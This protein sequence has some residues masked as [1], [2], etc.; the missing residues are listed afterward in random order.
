M[1]GPPAYPP[2]SAQP[3]SGQPPELPGCVRHPDRPTGLRCVRCDRPSCHECLR[4]AS[5]GYQCVDC[6]SVGR[7]QVRSPRTVAG[8]AVGGRAVVVPVLVAINLAVYLFTAVQARNPVD[9]Y[10][11]ALFD[12]WV[13][14]PVAVAD[15]EWWRLLTAG[16]LHYGPVHV[17]MNMLALWLIGRQLEPLLGSV[18][19]AAVYVLSLLGGS[20]AVF[21]FGAI[22]VAAAG[23]STGV[24][25]LFGAMLMAFLR[26]KLSLRP[27]LP[28][29]AINIVISLLPGIS[30]L[31]HLGGF[32][33]GAAATAAMLYAPAKQRTPVQIAAVTGLFLVI[34]VIT[35]S[36]AAELNVLF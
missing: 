30:L 20:A 26:L 27:L 4:E 18:R 16:F 25:G 8:A 32:A 17:A 35:M 9:N 19:F 7:R 24:Y 6:V 33:V 5:V 13:M 11:A 3:V 31:G 15:G 2:G 14:W 29:F 23:A 1:T 22:N 36:R 28:L 34:A 12:S 10:D 21:A